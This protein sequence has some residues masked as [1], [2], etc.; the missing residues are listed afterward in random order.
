MQ[1]GQGGVGRTKGR[2]VRKGREGAE[3]GRG[4]GKGG[5]EEKL[6]ATSSDELH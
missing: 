2:D 3:R 4:G 6:V 1:E 5:R